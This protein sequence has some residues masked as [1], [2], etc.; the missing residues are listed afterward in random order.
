MNILLIL[1]IITLFVLL[2]RER[3]EKERYKKLSATDPLTGL[4]NRVD[5]G[6]TS[7]LFEGEA[8]MKRGES[9]ICVLYVDI[10]DFKLFNDT[11]GHHFGDQVLIT[12]ANYLR[13]FFRRK[14]DQIIRLGEKSDEFVVVWIANDLKKTKAYI[15]FVCASLSCMPTHKHGVFFSGSIGAAIGHGE[16]IEKLVEIAEKKMY[17]HKKIKN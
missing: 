8:R 16:T 7:R 4:S 3:K 15:D 1:I 2:I 6:A 9:F 12:F 17:L 10:D 11:H 5:L 14:G 13:K